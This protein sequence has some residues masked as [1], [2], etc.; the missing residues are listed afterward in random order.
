[1]MQDDHSHEATVIQ[2]SQWLPGPPPTLPEP[3][4]RSM[5]DVLADRWSRMASVLKAT[6]LKLRPPA[7]TPIPTLATEQGVVIHYPSR[8]A[9]PD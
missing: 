9:L 8:S 7:S 2:L 1:M 3:K 4:L 5:A 6:W